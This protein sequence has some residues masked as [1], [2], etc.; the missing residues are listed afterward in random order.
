M[1]NGQPN[2]KVSEVPVV[3]AAEHLPLLTFCHAP[4]PLTRACLAVSEHEAPSSF[5]CNI[6]SE[7]SMHAT[8]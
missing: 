7:Y 8:Q 5:A 6:P 4:G 1:R 3:R 2:C